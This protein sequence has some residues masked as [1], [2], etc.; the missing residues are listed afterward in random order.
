CSATNARHWPCEPAL[1]GG[2]VPPAL[3]AGVPLRARA[4]DR[5][6]RSSFARPRRRPG[7]REEDDGWTSLAATSRPCHLSVAA[8]GGD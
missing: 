8:D 6:S 2:P 7:E 3:Q 1:R 5:A 4:V